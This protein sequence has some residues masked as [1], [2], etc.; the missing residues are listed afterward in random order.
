MV[1]SSIQTIGLPVELWRAVIREATTIPDEFEVCGS[2]GVNHTMYRADIY[3]QDW[4]EAITT[5]CGMSLVSK[6]FREIA[7][8]FLYSSILVETPLGANNLGSLFTALSRKAAVRW[9][10][11]FT[12]AIDEIMVARW[13][14]N[15]ALTFFPNLLVLDATEYLIGISTVKGASTSNLTT[16]R[17]GLLTMDLLQWLGCL[18][19]LQFLRCIHNHELH[20]PLPVELPQLQFLDINV[21]E[22]LHMA[23]PHQVMKMPNL[24]SIHLTAMVGSLRLYETMLEHHLPHLV[25]LGLLR[26]PSTLPPTPF[27]APNLRRLTIWVPW[28]N[29]SHLPGF[30]SIQYLEEIYVRLD[31]PLL[32]AT[33][34]LKPSRPPWSGDFE[35]LL[36][37]IAGNWGMSNLRHV[38][39]DITSNTLA[40]IPAGVSAAIEEWMHSLEAKGV[41]VLTRRWA[42]ANLPHE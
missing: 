23:P 16:V 40:V 12:C 24:R 9:V 17:V 4:H 25:S 33:N 20:L 8:E 15:M 21:L 27:D 18:P 10:R 1:T 6:T 2:N 7:L 39:T 35:A 32:L 5:R 41:L 19:R 11:R 22:T 3:R 31:E 30:I 34:R 37:G 42:A 26:V 13:A 28:L 14:I 38:Y 36:Q 29:W